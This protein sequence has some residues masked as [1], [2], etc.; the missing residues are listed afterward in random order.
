MEYRRADDRRQGTERRRGQDRR[1]QPSS[2]VPTGTGGLRV[3]Q[4]AEQIIQF[5]T[6]YL[7]EA[8]GLVFFNLAIERAPL[9]F[10]LSAIN[11]VYACH[12]VLN[13]LFFLHMLKFPNAPLRYR[14]AMWAD[15][16]LVGFSVLNDPNAIPPSVLAFIMVVLGNGMRYG[17]KMF[18]EAVA[19]CIGIAMLAISAR[20]L[21]LDGHLNAGLLFLNLFGGIILVYAYILMTRIEASRQQLEEKSK[22]DSLTGLYNRR[23]LFELADGIFER[24][25]REGGRLTLL[26][27]DMDKFKEV[28][29]SYGHAAGDRVLRQFGHIL[30]TSV[31]EHD[32]AA[33]FGGDE[34][35]LILPGVELA[36]GRRVAERIQRNVEAW[37][38]DAGLNCTLTVGVGEAPAQGEDLQSLLH[39]VD[40]A[41]YAAKADTRRGGVRLVED[42]AGPQPAI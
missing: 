41:M 25:H 3:P 24:M 12:I 31:R 33:R 40:Q 28:N 8:L 1:R 36:H 6:R 7:F 17:L 20:F 13:T 29:D 16:L 30:R 15:I 22:L 35:V 5:L 14:A 38:R 23:A 11:A 27:A 4:R 42:L 21:K 34:F 18:G 26:F 37:T 19:G 39:Q 32:L 10:E 9:W 2:S